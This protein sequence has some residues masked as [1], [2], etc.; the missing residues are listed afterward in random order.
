MTSADASHALARPR[1]ISGLR[2]IAGDYDV[3]FCDV[4]GVVHNGVVQFDGATNALRRFRKMGGRVILI[5]NAPRP[6]DRVVA[7]L[8][9]LKVPREAYD[10]LVTSGDVTISLIRARAGKPLAYIGPPEDATLFAA[11]QAEMK[12]KLQF[13][14]FDEA[15]YVVCI[16][17]EHAERESPAD[18]EARLRV[19]R[20]HGA[21][22]ICANPDVVVEMGDRLVFCA[23]ALAESYE[24]L[25]G[26]VIQAGK[27][28]AEI[29]RRALSLASEENK[30]KISPGRVLAIGD[31]ADTDIKGGHAQG[32]ATLFVTSGIHRAELHAEEGGGPLNRAALHQFLGDRAVTPT[33][34]APEL[35]W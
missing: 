9:K 29:Y 14:R 16:G 2:E 23:G 12:E 8:D 13:V 18:Y 35:V 32:F 6:R 26:R 33:A 3:I 17:L 31:S 22:F 20:T 5:T 19:L 28:H 4:W 25:G 10:G 1:F 15:D 27:P 7:F 21:E 34:I 11:A 24:A 30:M